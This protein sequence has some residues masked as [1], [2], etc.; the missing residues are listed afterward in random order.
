MI[1]PPS[2]DEPQDICETCAALGG[3]Q[4]GCLGCRKLRAKLYRE[5]NKEREL[6]KKREQY[7]NNPEL[8][9]NRNQEN[10]KKHKEERDAANRV[11][12]AKNPERR[13][14]AQRKY[15]KAHPEYAQSSDQR[16]KARL[17]AAGGAVR[18]GDR[19]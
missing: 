16:R 17:K 4:R 14:A 10:Y 2:A 1:A 11:W 18:R 8:F 7:Q 9:R 15:A 3:R 6:A 12:L 19:K 5:K 13:R